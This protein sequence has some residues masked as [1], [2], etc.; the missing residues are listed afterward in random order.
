MDNL[1]NDLPTGQQTFIPALQSLCV[2]HQ[3]NVLKRTGPNKVYRKKLSFLREHQPHTHTHTSLK[4]ILRNTQLSKAESSSQ[5]LLLPTGS[6]MF[7]M[8]QLT[9]SVCQNGLWLGIYITEGRCGLLLFA[10]VQLL[11]HATRSKGNSSPSFIL[12]TMPQIATINKQ[13]YVFIT[14]KASKAKCIPAVL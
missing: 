3:A 14:F 8:Q 9:T 6:T 1:K 13:G 2:N 4:T 10:S 7:S 12:P 11:T 5:K